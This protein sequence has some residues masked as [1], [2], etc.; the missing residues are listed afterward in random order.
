MLD[1]WY[2]DH[3]SWLLDL[4]ILWRTIAVVFFGET[5]NAAALE[6]AVAYASR[7][8]Q[9]DPVILPQPDA[10]EINGRDAGDHRLVV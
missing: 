2:V 3:R 4:R 10:A 5:P 9:P 7:Q 8:K 1:V 6:T